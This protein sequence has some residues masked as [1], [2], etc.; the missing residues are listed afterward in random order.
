[1]RSLIVFNNTEE[2]DRILS[3]L[4]F[5]DCVDNGQTVIVPNLFKLDYSNG[6]KCYS[7][8]LKITEQI[9]SSILQIDNNKNDIEIK[10]VKSFQ[11]IVLECDIV[12]FD[13]IIELSV[14]KDVSYINLSLK[15]IRFFLKQD[16]LDLDINIRNNKAVIKATIK[17]FNT[18]VDDV[19]KFIKRTKEHPLM[20]IQSLNEYFNFGYYEFKPSLEY[21]YYYKMLKSDTGYRKYAD[22]INNSS[23]EFTYSN[24]EYKAKLND[25]KIEFKIENI[26]DKYPKK[27]IFQTQS[28][29]DLIYIKEL[30]KYFNINQ[31]TIIAKVINIQ[32]NMVDLLKLDFHKEEEFFTF[33]NIQDK[34]KATYDIFDNTLSVR[35]DFNSIEEANK[36][37]IKE[38]INKITGGIL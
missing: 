35:Q 36:N 24:K 7:F 31:I 21:M 9:I 10:A 3:N 2:K 19:S 8:D 37:F 16:Y 20:Y 33:S 25:G 1:M 28:E 38:F 12:D 13:K 27:I 32:L 6:L 4:K 29:K 14:N 23:L 18:K 30:Q 5:K 17:E 15:E 11:Y 22:F 26:S 34:F